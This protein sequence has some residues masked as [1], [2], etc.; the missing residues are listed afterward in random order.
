MDSTPSPDWQT[1]AAIGVVGLTVLV[2][3]ARAVLRSRKKPGG[4]GKCGS[5]DCH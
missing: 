4:C 1:W 2:M 3:V 5:G